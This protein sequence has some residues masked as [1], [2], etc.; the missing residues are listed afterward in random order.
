MEQRQGWTNTLVET[1]HSDLRCDLIETSAERSSDQ[2]GSMLFTRQISEAC[3]VNLR[4]GQSIDTHEFINYGSY[5]SLTQCSYLT[6]A[7]AIGIE[8]NDNELFLK[9]FDSIYQRLR[10]NENSDHWRRDLRDFLLFP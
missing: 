6:I 2:T 8:E 5:S 1:I 4:T 7:A 9:K 10:R 3:V